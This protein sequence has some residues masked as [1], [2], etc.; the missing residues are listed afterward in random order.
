M[1]EK[2]TESPRPAETAGA[3][4]G[5][6][7]PPEQYQVAQQVAQQVAERQAASMTLPTI[8]EMDL[9][10]SLLPSVV[11]VE[12]APSTAEQ[13]PVHR[14]AAVLAERALGQSAPEP[15]RSQ[16]ARRSRDSNTGQ[17]AGNIHSS[18]GQSQP[19]RSSARQNRKLDQQIKNLENLLDGTSKPVDAT[20]SVNEAPIAPRAETTDNN[21]PADT[22]PAKKQSYKEFEAQQKEVWGANDEIKAEDVPENE[23]TWDE[24]LKHRPAAEDG[25]TMHHNGRAYEVKTGYQ[26]SQE[27]YKDHMYDKVQSFEYRTDQNEKHI[28]EVAHDEALKDNQEFDKEAGE[29]VRRITE[30][31]FLVKKDAKLS[32]ILELGEALVAMQ[33]KKMSRAK[34]EK[35]APDMAAR[36]GVIKDLLELQESKGT[37][38]R[39]LEYIKNKILRPYENY[40]DKPIEGKAT[41][42]GKEVKI[43]EF[44]ETPRG[45]KVYDIELDD[46]STETVFS[47]QVEFQRE[48]PQAE[49]LKGFDKLKAWFKNEA[50]SFREF[51]GAAYFAGRWERVRQGFK[52]KV[53]DYGVT[54]EMSDADKER[55]RRRNR[56]AVIA[57]ASL[58]AAGAVTAIGF[59]IAGAIDNASAQDTLAN[60]PDIGAGAAP[61]NEHDLNQEFWSG[62][63]APGAGGEVGGIDQLPLDGTNYD[64]IDTDSVTPDVLPTIPVEVFN[65]PSG[66]GGEE[67]FRNAGLDPAQW[68]AYEDTLLAQFPNDFYR[69]DGGHVGIAHSGWL[70]QG[71]QDFINSIR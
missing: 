6:R 71:A 32:T 26:V 8:E 37:D 61:V 51:G 33:N 38:P 5:D 50:K 44:T 30:G 62:H 66:Q 21:Q 19:R 52:D 42:G 3:T 36:E 67:L 7:L 39:A 1:V 69:M 31:E 22:E 65:I 10:S 55:K 41:F 57:G 47:H 34:A 17:H 56:I 20:A 4:I 53:L 11:K 9:E 48:Y 63:G 18:S 49:K 28:L 12:A 29:T 70:S 35:L 46:G 58:L 23:M 64:A 27:A 59:G 43:V 2:S 24:Y 54:D 25:D 16:P 40:G 68:Y 14:G 15:E 60:S 13:V 45:G